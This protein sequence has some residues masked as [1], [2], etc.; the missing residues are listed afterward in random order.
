MEAIA[1]HAASRK[2]EFGDQVLVGPNDVVLGDKAVI[3]LADGR[4]CFAMMTNLAK[5]DLK[6]ERIGKLADDARTL[7]AKFNVRGQLQRDFTDAVAHMTEETA[8]EGWPVSGPRT[9]LPLL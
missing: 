3:V 8:R 5:D 1:G 9:L 2:V 7:P 6:T 4:P